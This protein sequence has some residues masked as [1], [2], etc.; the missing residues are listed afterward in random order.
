MIYLDDD[1]EELESE[2]TQFQKASATKARR[3]EQQRI[4]RA[5]KKTANQ[6]SPSSLRSQARNLHP[7]TPSPT[8]SPAP[9]PRTKRLKVTTARKSTPEPI[10]ITTYIKVEKPA[11]AVRGKK[12]PNSVV[13]NKGPF[14]FNISSSFAE[15]LALAAA[16]LPTRPKLLVLP[17]LEWKYEK[18]ANDARKPLA[19]DAGYLAMKTSLTSKAKPSDLVVLLFMPPPVESDEVNLI[20]STVLILR[21][22]AIL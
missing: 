1:E 11:V 2:S 7:S 18:P 12:K 16:A 8:S 21:S 15:F 19:N 5:A 6:S 14:F 3:A 4:R 13:V 9:L 22:H 10:Q 17:K 20:L